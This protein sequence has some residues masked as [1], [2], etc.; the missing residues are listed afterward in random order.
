M[1]EELEKFLK[2]QSKKITDYLFEQVEKIIE[3]KSN[4]EVYEAVGL[5]PENKVEDALGISKS[6]LRKWRDCGLNR[7]KA[8]YEEASKYFYKTEEIKNFMI[9]DMED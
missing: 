5:I 2:A 8:P 4:L 6:T 9:E 7:Y 3:R 1:I